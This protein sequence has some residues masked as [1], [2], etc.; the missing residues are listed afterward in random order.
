MALRVWVRT[1]FHQG[2]R[3]ACCLLSQLWGQDARV[4]QGPLRSVD[5]RSCGDVKTDAQSLSLGP[6]LSQELSHRQNDDY[7]QHT[8]RLG[9]R[10]AREEAQE[11]TRKAS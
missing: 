7:A 2:E 9:E 11:R 5:A 10:R 8:G 6:C 3:R 1:Q 4:L